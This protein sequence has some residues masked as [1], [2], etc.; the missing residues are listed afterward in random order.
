MVVGHLKPANLAL[1]NIRNSSSVTWDPNVDGIALAAR[2][3][4]EQTLAARALG[5]TAPVTFLAWKDGELQ[6]GLEQRP[7][8]VEIG[9]ELKQ[10]YAKD[11]LLSEVRGGVAYGSVLAREGDF[12]GPVVNLASRI[13]SIANPG[14]ILVSDGIQKALSGKSKHRLVP[15][16]PRYLK[17][18]GS[19]QLWVVN[20]SD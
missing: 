6:S 2:R 1:Q 4:Q 18:L 19:V 11:K 17:D 12:Y 14:S 15:L 20:P 3:Q 7:Q 5:G 8:V 9:L 10:E 13:V 16:R